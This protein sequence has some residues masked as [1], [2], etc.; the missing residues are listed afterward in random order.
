[1]TAEDSSLWAFL[2]TGEVSL[3][4]RAT[5]E[6]TGSVTVHVD[7]D[8]HMDAL[9]GAGSVWVS[10]DRTPVHRISGPKPHIVADI[11]T[12]GGI[13]LAFAGG[14][15]WGARPDE[16]WAIDPE[17]NTVTRRVPLENVDEILALDI[18]ADA[19]QAWIAARRPGRVGT[20][21]ALDMGTGAVIGETPVSL[22]AG[23]R[24]TPEHAW[25]TDYDT[26]SLVGIA[27][28]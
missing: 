8:A 4:D 10:G 13:P 19:D 9:A 17:T 27:R 5:G 2:K 6:A 14:L 3:I 25:V 22:P 20:V 21:I 7:Q 23:V 24:L 26:D 16:L 1:M 18:D 11:E 12:G 28:D 15:V